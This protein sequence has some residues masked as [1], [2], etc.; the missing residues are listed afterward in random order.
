MALASTGLRRFSDTFRGEII[1]PGDGGYDAARRVWN[2]MF[3][4]RPALIVRP[5]T[6]ADVQAAVRLGRDQDWAIAVRGGGHSMSGMSTCDDGLVID[7]SLMRGVMVDP[8]ATSARVNGGAHLSELDTAAQ[9][10]GLV[11]PVGIVGHTGVGGL[12][13]GG[14]MGRLER[15]FGY[16][17][18]NLVA[19]ELVTADGR[20]VRATDTEEPDLFWAIRGAGANFGVVTAF[21]F[22]L[23][24]FG[25][26]LVRGAHAFAATQ[27]HE[28]W[29]VFRELS[30]S[31]PREV[32]GIT[33]SFNPPAVEDDEPPELRSGP[34]ILI[35]WAH[36]GPQE[37][38]ER[39]LASL[40]TIPAVQQTL[41]RMP[42]LD[43]QGMF[44][45]EMA[46]GHRF[47]SKAAFGNDL[48]PA[49]LDALVD[50]VA[51][52]TGDAYVS[53]WGQGGALRDLPDE[54]AAFTGRSASFWMIAECLWD[55]QERDA[56]MKAWARSAIAIVQ[57]E[58]V[59][60]NYVNGD[61]D[62]GTDLSAVYGEEKR[63]RLVALK[64][65][66]DPDNTF[67]LNQNIRP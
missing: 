33:I 52:I 12:T 41:S 25:P 43:V 22:R 59:T 6:V 53:A 23:H 67:R 47:Y 55:G 30:E 40:F 49:T 20:L 46:W 56:E 9:A 54:A 1:A 14:G 16:T 64:Q 21:E 38:A 17:I 8:R 37:A 39:D 3:D 32:A 5:A 2:G 31:A 65:A 63:R 62:P 15:R 11:C 13:L 44:D 57:P 29:A 28:A 26:D 36:T 60:G 27:V 42:Y 35:G 58:A 48:R 10:H 18:D 34:Y 66:W 61:S 51:K 7:L 19:V 45:E 24:P 50:H 4:R